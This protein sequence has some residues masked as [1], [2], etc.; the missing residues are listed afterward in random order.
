MAR[1]R[2]TG[3]SNSDTITEGSGNVFADLC[4]PDAAA[5][6]VKAQLTFQIAKRIKALGLTQ[7]AAA[8]VLVHRRQL[9]D[10]ART[11]ED[12]PVHDEAGI[13]SI[14]GGKR[15]PSGRI[16]IALIQS[17]VR[18]GEGVTSLATMET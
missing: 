15:K 4:M 14:G 3:M 9:L 2:R 10:L 12:L 6:L 16:D 18:E 13:G 5:E 8:A 1:N 11:A 7:T 17:L